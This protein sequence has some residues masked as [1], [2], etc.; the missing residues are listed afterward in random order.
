MTLLLMMILQKVVE[1]RTGPK[2]FALQLLFV[3]L[4]AVHLSKS[5]RDA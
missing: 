3:T 1:F 4:P 2:L 5:R